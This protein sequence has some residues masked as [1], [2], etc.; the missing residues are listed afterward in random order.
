LY[1]REKG[2]QFCNFVNNLDKIVNIRNKIVRIIK[3]IVENLNNLIGYM[4]TFFQDVIFVNFV[5]IINIVTK[6]TCSLINSIEEG[7][8]VEYMKDYSN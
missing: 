3:K 4:T 7:F 2:I 8:S 1:F 5:D 6:A